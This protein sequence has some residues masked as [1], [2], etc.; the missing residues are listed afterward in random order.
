M[1]QG[2]RFCAI[3]TR[4]LTKTYSTVWYVCIFL[5]SIMYHCIIQGCPPYLKNFH[6]AKM[7]QNYM[8]SRGKIRKIQSAGFRKI[9]KKSGGFD[10]NNSGNTWTT[11]VNF[12]AICLLHSRHSQQVFFNIIFTHCVTQQ[13]DSSIYPARA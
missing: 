8:K 2:C 9:G 7:N 11:L 5:S 4:F 6:P 3:S 12:K 13:T 1:I 10:E